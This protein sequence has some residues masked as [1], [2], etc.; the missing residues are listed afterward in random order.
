MIKRFFRKWKLN[1]R[2]RLH[3]MRDVS[4]LVLMAVLI[5]MALITVKHMLF[6][7]A[8]KS[9]FIAIES[10]LA[11]GWF[12]LGYLCSISL[13]VFIATLIATYRDNWYGRE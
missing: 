5:I 11:E 2:D 10:G 12:Y 1:S 4:A 8:Y 7:Q 6:F 9:I 13:V 3:S